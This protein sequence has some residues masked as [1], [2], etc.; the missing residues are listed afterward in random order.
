MRMRNKNKFSVNQ[1]LLNM[2]IKNISISK[3]VNYSRPDLPLLLFSF[4]IIIIVFFGIYC[5][6]F[7]N[8]N[9]IIKQDILGCDN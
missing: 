2:M 7:L 3:L 1:I 5:I 8:L 9:I 4:I 6:R